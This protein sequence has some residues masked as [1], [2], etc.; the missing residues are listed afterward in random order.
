[1]SDG[2]IGLGDRHDVGRDP[3]APLGRVLVLLRA[4][5]G[6]R[7]VAAVEWNGGGFRYR[8]VATRT[9]KPTRDVLGVDLDRAA[10]EARE[11]VE[12]LRRALLDE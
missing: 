12:L 11:L 9:G 8:L 1:M 5:A 2:G 7:G 10:P 6:R 3:R 4:L